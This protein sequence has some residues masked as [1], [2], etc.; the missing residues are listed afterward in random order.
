[1]HD[2]ADAARRLGAGDPGARATGGDDRESAELAEAFNAM[3]DRLE[4]SEML[5]R[6]AASDIAHDLATPATV[7]ES[8]LQAMIDGVVPDRPRGPRG[9]ALGRR[10]ARRASWPTS[11]T[12]PAP[13]RRR[14]RPGP[15]AVD[16]T[17][18]IPEVALALDGPRRERAVGLEVDGRRR[19][20]RV[21]RPGP[22][23]AGRSATSS[24]NAHRPQ[25]G[26]R[27]V[28]SVVAAR[29][30]GA[31]PS[32]IRVADQGPGIAPDDVPHVFERFYRADTGPGDRPRDRPAD[33]ARPRADDRPRAARGERRPDRA[34]SGPG[35]TG[36][37]FLIDLP[38][39]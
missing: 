20:R 26:R 27:R 14:S 32:R 11:T 35:P 37:T 30:P 23:R 1:M 3:A 13:R 6:R 21:G 9:G 18:A 5:R 24:A 34:S 28:V 4:R 15:R 8:Q 36:T 25:P 19:R 2:V 10:G 29:R 33:R 7:L 17:D 39:G 31:G 12:S 22:P 38:R 16:L